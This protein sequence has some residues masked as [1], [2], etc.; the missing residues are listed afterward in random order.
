LQPSLFEA[1]WEGLWTPVLVSRLGY[2]AY[3]CNACGQVCPT[4]AIPSL[5]L[6]EKRKAVIGLAYIDKNRCI[7]WA[8][9]RGCIVCE[10]MCPVPEKAIVLE[11]KDVV[12]PDGE[13]AT[14]R[15]PSVIRKRCIGCGICETKC[16]VNGDAAIRVYVSGELPTNI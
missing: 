2:C 9:G 4:G 7:P 15:L 5:P 16:P 13:K 3:S 1:G 8:D 10:E 12:N 11:E 6:D 14:V